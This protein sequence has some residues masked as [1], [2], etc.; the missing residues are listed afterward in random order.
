MGGAQLSFRKSQKTPTLVGTSDEGELFIV[1]WTIRPTEENPNSD[2]V[3]KI[4]QN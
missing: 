1:D 4:W 3:T 2:L